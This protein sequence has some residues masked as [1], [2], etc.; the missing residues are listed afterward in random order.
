MK[1]VLILAC[2]AL[3]VAHSQAQVDDCPGSVYGP[4]QSCAGGKNEGN[5][6]T[7]QCR[8]YYNNNMWY[9]DSRSRSCKNM[10]YRGCAGN[11]NRY[12]TRQSCE[13]KCVRRT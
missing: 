7:R 3:F 12:C 13:R 5:S 6:R 1:F 11:D 9:Y 10:I 2:L 8:R 4:R